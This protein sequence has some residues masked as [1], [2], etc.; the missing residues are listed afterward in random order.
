MNVFNIKLWMRSESIGHKN[1]GLKKLGLIMFTVKKLNIL[2]WREVLVWFHRENYFFVQFWK[3]SQVMWKLSMRLKLANFHME[4]NFAFFVHQ[5]CCRN[6]FILICSPLYAN[7][8]P[9]LFVRYWKLNQGLCCVHVL[10]LGWNG[11]LW[12]EWP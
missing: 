2:E 4:W 1:P 8:L 9:G 10:R 12:I 11:F 3:A 6:I 7:I 5:A